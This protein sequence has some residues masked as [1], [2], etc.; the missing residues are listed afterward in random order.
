M[1][2]KCVVGTVQG[3]DCYSRNDATN[4]GTIR[5]EK[6]IESEQDGLQRHGVL[7]QRDRNGMRERKKVRK[8]L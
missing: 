7:M 5:K 8:V 2:Y 3:S 1:R 4:Q 6:K